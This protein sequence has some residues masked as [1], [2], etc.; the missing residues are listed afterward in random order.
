VINIQSPDFMNINYAKY[1][2]FITFGLIRTLMDYSLGAIAFLY[3]DRLLNFKNNI[4]NSVIQVSILLIVVY[5]YCK[6]GYNRSNEIFAPI[7]FMLLIISLSKNNG[8]LYKSFSGRLGNFMGDISYP[9]YMMH[10]LLIIL[11]VHVI[12]FDITP[13]CIALYTLTL[14]II[15]KMVNTFIE[16]PCLKLMQKT[17]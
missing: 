3:K 6:N 7:L 5:L 16:K 9:S 8:I 2:G 12:D 11:F 14:L 17:R 1:F 15:S 13:V 4:M 10:P